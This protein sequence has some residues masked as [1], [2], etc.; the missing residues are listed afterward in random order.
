MFVPKDSYTPL[1]S[2]GAPVDRTN[3]FIEYC[4]KDDLHVTNDLEFCEQSVFSLSTFYNNGTLPCACDL[5]GSRSEKC[6]E[7]GG[8]CPCLE[9]VIG[10]TCTRCKS[11]YY[12]FPNCKSKYRKN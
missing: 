6:V 9:N 7:F 2:N 5:R 10:R 12:G 11:G 3:D 1:L 8:Q 4:S